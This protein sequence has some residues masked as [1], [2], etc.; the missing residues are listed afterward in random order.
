MNKVRIPIITRI[1]PSI[2]AKDLCGIQPITDMASD[3][4]RLTNANRGPIVYK[5]GELVHSFLRGY[6]RYYGTSFISNELWFK[7]K[8]KGL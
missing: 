2:L 6:Q 7:L 1:I 4:F 5:Q 3:I 8:I